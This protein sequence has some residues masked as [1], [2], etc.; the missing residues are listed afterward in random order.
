[1]TRNGNCSCSSGI[2]LCS[3]TQMYVLIVLMV[4]GFLAMD[5]V[6]VAVAVNYCAQCELLIFLIRGLNER[7]E[8]KSI[9][10]QQA[11]RVPT[12]IRCMFC[13]WSLVP[14]LW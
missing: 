5:M 9:P 10:L 6:Y 4:I 8:E 7:I 2:I 1:M 14:V 13:F 12:R 3:I 11:I